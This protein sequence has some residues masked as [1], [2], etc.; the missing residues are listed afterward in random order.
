V[1]STEGAGSAIVDHPDRFVTR[2]PGGG[3]E[4]E[5]AGE[6]P[7][8]VEPS[9]DGWLVRGQD[10]A[11]RWVLGRAGEEGGG[12]VLIETETRTEAGRTMPLV[13]VDR[14]AGPSFLLLKDGR[15]FRMI[16]RGPRRAGYELL[17]WETPGAYLVARP[18]TKGWHIEATPAG[19]GIVDIAVITILF[20]AEILDCEEPLRIEGK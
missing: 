7:I 10:A 16:M 2:S 20:A 8:R 11:P 15:L 5:A 14:E 1:R 3:F 9:T 6:P 4:I 18:M 13:G 12:L 17:G 19:G